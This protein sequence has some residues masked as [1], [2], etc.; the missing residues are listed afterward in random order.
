[1]LQSQRAVAWPQRGH[2]R[3]GLALGILAVIALGL[4]SRRF[5]EFL[6]AV[7]G[8]Y[9][10]D[11]LWGLMVFLGIALLKPGL[12]P[13]RL[14]VWALAA[15]YVVEF[16]QLYQAPWI[17]DIRRTT[18]GHLALGS[19][20]DRLDLCAYALGIA[21]GACVDAQGTPSRPKKN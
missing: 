14:T 1:M 4:A 5:P 17:N 19:G 7:L 6:P 16:S 11:G 12:S 18:L 20:F 15:C 8:K 3:L 9:P 2:N 13:L 21:C 10:G